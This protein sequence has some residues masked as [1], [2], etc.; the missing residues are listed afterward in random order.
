MTLHFKFMTSHKLTTL[1]VN[2]RLYLKYSLFPEN[3]D[4]ILVNLQPYSSNSEFIFLSLQLYSKNLLS[5]WPTNTRHLFLLFPAH[6]AS[7]RKLLYKSRTAVT[8]EV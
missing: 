3:Q 8:L 5:L 7:L 1:L 4:F 6:T 2:L